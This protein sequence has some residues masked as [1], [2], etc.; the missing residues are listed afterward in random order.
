MFIVSGKAECAMLKPCSGH[1]V[2][3]PDI[4][5]SIFIDYNALIVV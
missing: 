2:G 4:Q 1:S 3:I 5:R